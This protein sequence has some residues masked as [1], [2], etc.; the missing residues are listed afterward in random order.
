MCNKSNQ[1]ITEDGGNKQELDSSTS[2]SNEDGDNKQE[3]DSS[4][5]RSNMDDS[6]EQG[7]ANSSDWI[8][9]MDSDEETNSVTQSLSKA[10]GN[11]TRQLQDKSNSIYFKNGRK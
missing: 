5:S 3:L 8:V 11:A 1:I 2:R 7:P 6:N 4:T 9:A 10:I